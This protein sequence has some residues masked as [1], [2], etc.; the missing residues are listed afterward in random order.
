MQ[1]LTNA[2]AWLSAH[3]G[4]VAGFW[5]V[6]SAVVV[7]IFKPRTGADEAA[8]EAEW[9]RLAAVVKA[10]AAL[11][12]DPIALLQALAKLAKGA[13][14]G[15]LVLLFAGSLALTSQ[16]CKPSNTPSGGDAD[17][18]GPTV[19]QVVEA[20]VGATDG[21]CSFLE[22]VDDSGVV[23][24]ICATV[25]E[26]GQVIEFILTLRSATDAGSPPADAACTPITTGSAYVC[27]TKAEIAKGI[28]FLTQVRERRVTR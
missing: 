25:L 5:L 19:V 14:K 13:P 17:A 9:P 20:G 8:F 12:L 6:T 11:G 16:A 27:A 28:L 23:R 10:V 24:T 21:V 7:A 2:W 4:I 3:H 26:I 1:N 18:S 15:P 22:G